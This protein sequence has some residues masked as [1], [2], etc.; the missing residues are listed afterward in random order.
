M[1][2]DQTSTLPGELLAGVLG[3]GVA[4]VCVAPPI[5]HLV[6]GPLGPFIGGFVAASHARPGARGRFVIA[7]TIATGLSSILA[8]ALGVLLSFAVPSDFPDWFP[9]RPALAGILAGIWLYAA[10][11]AASGAAVS[12]AVSRKQSSAKAPE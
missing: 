11:L 12:N 5:V 6:T 4:V 1:N 10:V 3:A 8:I 9:S 2:E 7:V